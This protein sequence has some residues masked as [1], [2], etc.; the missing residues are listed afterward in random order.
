[1]THKA[2]V[3]LKLTQL[4]TGDPN[5]DPEISPSSNRASLTIDTMPHVATGWIG[6]HY[7]VFC[8][9]SG[10]R[11]LSVKSIVTVKTWYKF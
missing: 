11:K 10:Q 4:V 8:W 3:S 2:V 6:P 7:Y 5:I 1:M 9:A